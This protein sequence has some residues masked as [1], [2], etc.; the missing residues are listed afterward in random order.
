MSKLDWLRELADSEI[1]M[2]ESGII[3]F[4]AGFDPARQLEEES[5]KFLDTLKEEFVDYAAAFN[6]MRNSVSQMGNIKIYG[7]SQTRADFML[8]RNGFKLIFTLI[9]PGRI[10]IRPHYQG[11]SMIPG[12]SASEIRKE[13]VAGD[14]ILIARWGA[15]GEIQWTHQDY[16]VNSDYLVRFYLSKFIR[17]SAK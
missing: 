17:D 12:Q 4:Q 9:E 7:I 6:Q 14:D 10:A 15:Y 16:P 1:K 3:D 2:E 13:E 5:Y 11:V 8:F